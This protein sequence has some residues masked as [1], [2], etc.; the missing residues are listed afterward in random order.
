MENSD[1]KL[2]DKEVKTPRRKWA[3]ER[4]ADTGFLSRWQREHQ[5]GNSENPEEDED[6]DED[7]ESSTS[8]PF[9]NWKRLGS[10][11]L[12]FLG[13]KNREPDT[14]ET[15][16]RS[17]FSVEDKPD[18]GKDVPEETPET[19]APTPTE[20]S[21]PEPAPE[22][23]DREGEPAKLEA[24]DAPLEDEPVE[25]DEP[26]ETTELVVPEAIEPAIPE[27]ETEDDEEEDTLVATATAS[28]TS[29]GSSG[30]GSGGAA[31][32]GSRGSGTNGSGGSGTRGVPPGGPGS[33]SNLNTL[34]P[35]VVHER[36]LEK[37]NGRLAALALLA[38]GAEYIGRRRAVNRLERADDKLAKKNEALKKD[39]DRLAREK[40]LET[41]RNAAKERRVER[42]LNEHQKTQEVTPQV[43]RPEAQAS[44]VHNKQPEKSSPLKP[45]MFERRS[46]EMART[47]VPAAEVT[48]AEAAPIAE[49]VRPATVERTEFNTVYQRA[50]EVNEADK[51]VAV[52][53]PIERLYELRHE[54]KDD[55]A[56]T[57][58]A[59]AASVGAILAHQRGATALQAAANDIAKSAAQ[60]RQ[61]TNRQ[62]YQTA[63]TTGVTGALVIIVLAVIAYLVV[64]AVH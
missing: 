44:N 31:G 41:T 62:L 51:E 23:P 36:I 42:R 32:G 10:G 24:P 8:K 50:P 21:S 59:H 55:D 9:K 53:K 14:L 7:E 46:S 37:R 17:I 19:E 5:L 39:T 35:P 1:R 58:A 54:A 57:V 56:A 30:G 34:T 26:S 63:V 27:A 18:T 47:V 28:G 48:R 20:L 49:A 6:D 43:R 25:L 22:A 29:G 61:Q 4:W 33:P 40:S 11:L 2:D 13:D 64:T 52:D 12:K 3:A 15:K 16:K 38:T 60:D 45:S